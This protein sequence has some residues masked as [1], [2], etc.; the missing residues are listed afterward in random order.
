MSRNDRQAAMRH[1]G[2]TLVELMV[3]LLIAS[4][5]L[6]IAVS[7]YQTQIQHSRRTDAK[8]ALLD[9]AGREERLF[10]TTN[11]YSTDPIALGYAA[12]GSG[13][14]FPM[15]VGSNYYTVNIVPTVS[16][17]GTPG[18]AITAVPVAATS[19]ANDSNCQKFELDSNG[20]Q[21]AYDSTGTVVATSSCW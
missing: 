1:S 12:V 3:V 13:A 5:L 20:T 14:S 18:Y 9:L 19:Q 17:N 6:V 21:L 4:I 15:N 10:A 8:T 2:F 16:A 11:A 7:G